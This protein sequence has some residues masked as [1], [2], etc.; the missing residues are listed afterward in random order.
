[1]AAVL[2]VA[3]LLNLWPQL[4][5]GGLSCRAKGPLA[6]TNTA[7][8]PCPFMPRGGKDFSLLPVPDNLTTYC[9]VH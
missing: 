9:L 8:S 6:S 3:T 1:M 5:F 7:P 4:Q 2:A